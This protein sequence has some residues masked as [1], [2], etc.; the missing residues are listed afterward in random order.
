MTEQTKFLPN[1]VAD[2]KAANFI[3]GPGRPELQGATLVRQDSG[4]L[5]PASPSE[6]KGVNFAVYAPQAQ[7]LELCL[8]DVD[9]NEVRLLM[10]SSASGVWHLYV[11]NLV[12]GQCYGFRADGQWHPDDSPRF[13]NQKLLLDP[14]SRE[15]RGAVSWH[16]ALFDYSI[17]KATGAWQISEIDSA[18]VMPRSVVRKRE[19]DWQGVTKP[20]TSR[21]DSIIY[22]LH[23]KGF[24]IQNDAVPEA[25]RG[26]YLGLS[27]PSSVA[28]LKQL[29]VT[30][31]EL[32]PVTSK[33][34]EERLNDLGLSNYWGYNPLCLM[35]PEPSLAIDD[36]VTEMKTMVRELHRAGIEVILDVVFNHTCESGHG[37]PSLSLRGLSE[38]DYYLIDESIDI[39]GHKKIDSTNYTGCGNTMN[40]DCPQ[41]LKLTMDALRCWVEE[42]QVDGFRFDLA[43]TMARQGRQFRRDS[44]F[45]QAIYQDP[46]LSQCKMIAE[47]WDI[48]PDGYRL[49]GFPREWQEWNDRYRDG[50]RSFWRGDDGRVA[51]MGWRMVG[52]VDVFGA[53][54]PVASINYICSHDG[55]TLNDLV[56]YEQRHNLAN[57]ENNRDGDAH[58]YSC[59]YGVEGRTTNSHIQAKRLRAR[60]NMLATLMLSRG[61]PMVMAGDEFGNSQDGNNNA[62]CQDSPLS[63]L[64]WSWQHDESAYHA[65]ELQAFTASLI[66]LRKTHPLLQGDG[67]RLNIHWL[68]RHGAQLNEY[69]LGQVKGGCLGVKIVSPDSDSNSDKPSA[70][71]VLMN[72]EKVN[73]RFTF[74]DRH[75]QSF[76]FTLLDTSKPEPVKRDVLLTRGWHLV[77]EQSL[78]IVEERG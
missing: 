24:S 27:H 56:S 72:S 11:E 32:L 76:W 23:V 48:G 51:D 49:A 40:F 74:A 29:G 55:F 39:R 36:P 34:S 28:Y 50:I 6:A 60:R 58:N 46:V 42:Y 26:T 19:F 54:R 13:N 73:R 18:G 45:F 63:W 41:T 66:E 5:L 7:G 1:A 61:V 3:T 14:Y 25:L 10:L 77:A 52:S 64:D 75:S 9:D 30:T 16:P 2:N 43:P 15:V 78:V 67:G 33:V 68:D 62:Y 47:P 31:V 59:N 69:Q 21:T 38:R 22:E 44:A 71:F 70:L 12:A 53:D 57:G 35:A 37:G 8:F 65:R 17:S 4:R 20:G